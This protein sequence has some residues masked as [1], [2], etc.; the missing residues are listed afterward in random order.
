VPANSFIA[1]AEAV[2]AVG[3]RPR[4]CDVDPLTGLMTAEIARAALT[5]AV[6]CIAPVHLFG[7]TVDMDPIVELARERGIA[8]LE[9]ACQAHGAWYRGRRAGTIGDAG[10]FSFYPAKNLGAWGDGGA[11]VTDDA[12]LAD[13]VALLRSHGERPRYNH[14]M[15]GATAR[16]DGLQAAVLRI[17]LRRLEGWN[18]ERRKAAD[19][20]RAGLA[21]TGVGLPAEAI[22]GGDHVHHLFVIRVPDRDRVRAELSARGV[23]TGVHYPVPIHR[24]EAYADL[25]MGPGSLPV[26]EAMAKEI[27]SLPIHPGMERWE[28]DAIVEA[29]AQACSK[30]DSETARS[31]RQGGM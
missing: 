13:R 25:G 19:A 8:V 10:C 7:A 26:A 15:V 17:K 4:F 31:A 11:V 18:D 30:C 23:A 3:A 20:L 14:R 21:A 28:I 2:S 27:C 24:T 29:V 6:R 16:L 22:T 5:S 12:E 1:T 9:D